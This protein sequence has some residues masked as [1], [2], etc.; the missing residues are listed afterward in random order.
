MI[1]LFV[2]VAGEN[3]VKDVAESGSSLV[4]KE[5]GACAM[6]PLREFEIPDPAGISKRVY[7]GGVERVRGEYR[8]V[9]NGASETAFEI[10]FEHLHILKELLINVQFCLT[11]LSELLVTKE[12]PS[13][14]RLIILEGV[15]GGAGAGKNCLRCGRQSH[16]F[17]RG[18]FD[19]VGHDIR[20][21]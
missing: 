4:T 5:F 15:H 13:R 10:V 17:N 12:T 3:G 20:R 1:H 19:F 2:L 7:S 16:M 18:T 21:W 8:R 14:F 9:T 6:V 11:Q